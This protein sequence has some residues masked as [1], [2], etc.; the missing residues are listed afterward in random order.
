MKRTFRFVLIVTIIMTILL[1]GCQNEKVL[2]PKKPVT[3][4][5]WHNFGAQMKNTMDVM[6]DEFNDTIGAE[7]GIILNV[8]SISGSATLHEKLTMA[9]NGDPGAPKLPD[10]TTA[11]PKTALTLAEK[12]LLVDLGTLFTEEELSA[13]VSRFVEEGRLTE[14]NLYVFPFAKSTEVMF[15]NKTIFNRFAKDTGVKLE[16]LKTFE[17]VIQA[18]EKYYT[19]TDNQTPD[20]KNDGKMFYVADSLFN[21]AQIGFKQLGEDFIKNKEL[22]LSSPIFSRIW[23]CFYGPAVRGHVAIFDGYG[24]DLAKTGD[25][26]CTTGSTAGVLFF[27]PIVTYA[28]N[29]TEPAEYAILPYP[30]FEGGQKIAMQRGSGM[31]VTKSTPEKEYAAGVFLKWFTDPEQNLRFVSSTG[32]LPVTKQAFGNVMNKEIETIADERIKRLLETAIQMQQEYD[33]YIPPQFDGFD[34]MQKEYE[35]NLKMTATESKKKYQELLETQN[36]DL[37]FKMVSEG[38]LEKITE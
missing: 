17:G 14:E 6:V 16:D 12:N 19:W 29:T 23:D 11:Y 38:V 27:S 37:A 35:S 1:A 8:T 31:C 33:F 20:I 9:A 30:V 4:I 13:Y 34:K 24:S 3:L 32:Y 26:V 10:I 2:N 7:K 36:P 21:F 15:L 22:N 18:A 25:V 28:D 5:L